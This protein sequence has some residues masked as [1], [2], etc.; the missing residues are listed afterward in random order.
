MFILFSYTVLLLHLWDMRR[1]GREGSRDDS[2]E[3]QPEDILSALATFPALSHLTLNLQLG[4]VN[5]TYTLPRLDNSTALSM[6]QSIRSQK[7]GKPLQSL[8]LVLGEW[9][10]HMGGGLRYPGWEEDRRGFYVCELQEGR[11][12]CW[13]GGEDLC[14]D[15]QNAK[16][17]PCDEGGKYKWTD[18]GVKDEL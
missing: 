11:E 1:I 4:I 6:F 16:M 7:L 10:E 17:W 8:K 2:N 18:G 3:T 12:S 15:G 5:E 9:G 13:V 14:F